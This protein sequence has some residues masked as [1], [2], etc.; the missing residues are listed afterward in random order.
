MAGSP[1][2][3]RP[4]C[5]RSVRVLH[6]AKLA[7]GQATARTLQGLLTSLLGFS[8]LQAFRSRLVRGRHGAVTR[9]VSLTLGRCVGFSRYRKRSYQP[10]QH[11]G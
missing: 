5:K 9:Y 3:A 8:R 7:N 1:S 2:S 11:K 4:R 6:A 10:R